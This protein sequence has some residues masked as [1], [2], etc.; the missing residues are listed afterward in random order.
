MKELVCGRWVIPDADSEVIENGAVLVE[1]GRIVDVGPPTRCA[2]NMTMPRCLVA[3]SLPSCP[4]SSMPI[5]TL[6]LQV[7]CSTAL[8]T[9]CWKAG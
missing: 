8:R 4:A 5:I 6:V 2:D 3:R 7:M 1:N 9:C